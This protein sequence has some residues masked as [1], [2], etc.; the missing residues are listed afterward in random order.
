M[1]I[2]ISRA[3]SMNCMGYRRAVAGPVQSP[4]LDTDRILVG[5]TV[6][7]AQVFATGLEDLYNGVETKSWVVE[8]FLAPDLPF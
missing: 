7:S 5:A 4:S 8:D 1:L 6:A 3:A 2:R